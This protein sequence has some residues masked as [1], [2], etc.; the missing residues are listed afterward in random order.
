MS[1]SKA[2]SAGLLAGLI[3]GIAMT[4]V[5]LVLACCGVA[6]PLA[7][8]GDRLSVFIKPGPFLS[9]MGRV[10]G[11]NHLKQLGVGSTMAGQ[12]FVGA[13]AGAIFGLLMRRNPQ[14]RVTDWTM[15]IFVVLPIAA[16]A[17][18]LWP[19]L[20]T[21][22]IGL[23][24]A[25]GGAVTLIGFA[26]SVL[27]FERTL[28]ASFHF[29]TRPEAGAESGEFT[30]AI[31]RRALILGG[32]G[33]LIAGGGV[34]LLRRLYRIATFSYD[35]TQYKGRIVQ[36]IT[37]NDLFYCVTKNVIDPRVNV[38]LWH[39]EVNGLV[40]NPTTYRFQDLKG[41]NQVEQETTL[42]CISNGLDAGLI[43]NAV[44]KGITLRDLID[45]AGPM[46]DA[47]RVRLFGVDNYTDTIPL[48]KALDPTTL[49]AWE[50]NGRSLPDRHGYPLR[51]IVPGYFGEKHVKWLTRIELTGDNV[52]G[53][54]ETQGWGPDFM[55]PTR[56]RIDAPDHESR[57]SLGQ[58]SGP[59]EVKG[60]AFGGDRGISRVEIS[61]DDGET[62]TD[63]NVHYPGTK[64]TWAL[65]TYQWRPDGP[66]DYTLV[67]RATDGE[68]AVQEWEEDRSPFSGVTGFHKITVHVTA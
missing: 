40:Q 1:R 23:P 5:M 36:P 67:V 39:L 46:A 35:G 32:L 58:L 63:G 20:G 7:I 10:G 50:M 57:F 48:E 52:K 13:L 55:T 37:P 17:I 4:V 33:V 49:L 6:T 44:W 15:S 8:I 45:P 61:D 29:L 21:S 43:S 41:F 66:D 53:F 27:V 51:A 28:V 38:D 9:I 24:I 59:I 18:A 19:V 16:I 62:W 31:G 68:G 2:F 25:S 3:A 47:R 54:Y 56:S 22:Y 65:W 42:M 12:L 11:Y 30:P 60:I 26:L 34:G 14:R 64:L